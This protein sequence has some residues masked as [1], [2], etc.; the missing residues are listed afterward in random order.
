[1]VTPILPSPE[2]FV[3]HSWC[4]CARISSTKPYSLI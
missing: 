3:V 2:S 1:M 4:N